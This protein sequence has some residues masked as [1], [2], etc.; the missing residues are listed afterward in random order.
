MAQQTTN[1]KPIIGLM[2]GPGSGKSTAANLFAELGCAI[3]DADRLAH[4]ALQRDAVKQAVREKWGG[5]VF[6][7]NDAI[8]RAALGR[9]V[10][11]DPAELRELEA[12][13]HPRVH[14]GRLRERERYQADASVVAIVEDCPLLLESKLDRQCD[15]LVFV[16]APDDARLQRVHATRAWDA[17]ELK[18]RDERQLSLDTKRQAADYVISNDLDLAHLRKQVRDVLQSITKTKPA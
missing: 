1:D 15:R 10:F 5:G 6:D 13:I 7:S 8:D 16:D 4:E 11:A 14:D 17:K 12:I 18:K 9:I 3:I 2:G